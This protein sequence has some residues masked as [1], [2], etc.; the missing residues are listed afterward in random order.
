MEGEEA[1]LPD[2][3]VTTEYN[4]A[5]KIPVLFGHYWLAGTTVISNDFA[6]CVD[7]SVAKQGYLAAY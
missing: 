4:Y 3:P 6:A 7:F 1:R 5:D 2:L